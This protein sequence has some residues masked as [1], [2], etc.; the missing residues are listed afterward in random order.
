LKS[1]IYP[2]GVR[3]SDLKYTYDMNATLV[4]VNIWYINITTIGEMIDDVLLTEC[5][6]QMMRKLLAMRS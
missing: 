6:E 3:K 2:W 1:L 4:I 5:E